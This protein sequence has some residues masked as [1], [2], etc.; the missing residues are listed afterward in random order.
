MTE[1]QEILRLIQSHKA[2]ELFD[3]KLAVDWAID[4]IGEGNETDNVLMLASFSEPIDKYEI[5]PY[6]TA[7]LNDLE[8]EELECD[9]ALIAQTHFFLSKILKNEAIRENLHSLSQVCINNDCDKRIM[10]FYLLYHGWRELE[11]IGANYY[12]EGANLNNIERVLKNEA[13]I[14]IDKYVFGKENFEIQRE[15]EKIKTLPTTVYKSKDAESL[16]L[17]KTRSW[18]KKLWS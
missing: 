5:S 6:V 15:L 17:N 7:V 18:W 12:Y 2:L 16:E 1:K 3:Y 4:L 9:D 10:V 11:E 8:L 13:R 14:W